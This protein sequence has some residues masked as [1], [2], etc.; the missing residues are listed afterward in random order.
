MSDWVYIICDETLKEY[1]SIMIRSLNIHNDCKVLYCY[2]GL[3]DVMPDN[4]LLYDVK[5]SEWKNK[6]Q[7]CKIQKI[8][9]MSK[10][11]KEGDKVFILDVDILVQDNIFKV[12][13]DDFDIGYTTR[14][15]DYHY[16]INGG[17]WCIR[18]NERSKRFIDF[19][20]EQILKPSWKPLVNFRGRY[21]RGKNVNWWVDQDFLCAV[22]ENGGKLPFDC[23]VRDL[24]Y[25]YNFCPSAPDKIT[26]KQGEKELRDKFGNKEY[27]ILHF[28]ATMK[29][30]MK[31]L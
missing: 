19:F 15:Y 5:D 4:V 21:P 7:L 20:I 14:H 6:I 3:T 12:F 31:E 8:K 22:Y 17:V 27:K 26:Y 29:R 25:K 9:E 28:K 16:P 23:K 13:E 10:N 30:L 1:V 11:F 18:W 2:N 24:G